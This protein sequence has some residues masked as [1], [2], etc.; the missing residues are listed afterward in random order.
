LT[1]T[2]RRQVIYLGPRVGPVETGGQRFD[3]A[4]VAALQAAGWAT[5]ALSPPSR[6]RLPASVRHIE[7]GL[8]LL[9]RVLSLVG[10]ATVVL[11][12]LFLH[13]RALPLNVALRARRRPPLV[14]IAHH[15]TW[16]DLDAPLH[17][18][19]DRALTPV[20]LRLADHIVTV[21]ESTKAAL[22]AMG[23]DA[24]RVHLIRNGTDAPCRD[25]TP[26]D[27]GWLRALFVGACVPRKGLE[28]LIHALALL[29][30]CPVTLDIVGD[31]DA[32]RAYTDTVVGLTRA[33]SLEERIT[34]HGAVP[35]EALWEH[36]ARADLFVL[37]SLWEGYG[38]VLLE[39]TAFA[40]PI[41]ATR[42]GGVGELVSDGENGLLAPP[43]D[44]VAL[45]ALIRRLCT[46]ETLRRRLEVGSRSRRASLRSVAAAQAEFVRLFDR[47]A[48][49]GE[50]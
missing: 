9:G 17:R 13:S 29:R 47:L 36:Y 31:L 37:P 16:H 45:A 14:L 48:T 2:E 26:R 33:L 12:N 22:L 10:D 38:V 35:R 50:G 20:S 27:D 1:A 46:D 30:D 8:W 25:R 21:S 19:V 18:A 41:V 24:E 6:P 15:A 43:R 44:P 5:R 7:D 32:A 49:R 39:A 40:L 28:V 23:A 42:V 3:V 11:E 4:A 34:F